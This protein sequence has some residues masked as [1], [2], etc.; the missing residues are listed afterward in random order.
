MDA[1][2][3]DVKNVGTGG[4]GTIKYSS[5]KAELDKVGSP[6]IRLDTSDST[7]NINN[8]VLFSWGSAGV[9]DTGTFSYSSYDEYLTVDE[10]GTYDVQLDIGMVRSSSDT[11]QAPKAAL[12]KNRTSSG[13]GGTQ[14]YA[15]GKTGYMRGTDS[16]DESSL[17]I[18]WIGNLSANDTLSIQMSEGGSSGVCNAQPGK[19]NMYVRKLKRP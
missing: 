17:H 13:S 4:G 12:Y 10:S 11:R 7:L 5:L 1:N 15:T 8:T 9:I 2:G 16:H 19:T 14:L 6:I 3:N 18:S